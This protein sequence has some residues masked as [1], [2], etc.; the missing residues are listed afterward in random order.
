MQL[1][2]LVCVSSHSKQSMHFNTFP[3]MLTLPDGISSTVMQDLFYEKKTK[4]S[5][6]GN[7]QEN[8]PPA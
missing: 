2:H 6:Q 5:L 4:S 7:E 3:D 1:V 8:W